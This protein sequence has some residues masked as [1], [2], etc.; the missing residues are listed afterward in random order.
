M[1]AELGRIKKAI[2]IGVNGQDGYFLAK[3]L[4][5]RGYN[6]HGVSRQKKPVSHVIPYINGYLCSDLISLSDASN[7]VHHIL[8]EGPYL[9]FYCA[10][11][12]ASRDNRSLIEPEIVFTVNRDAFLYL[13]SNINLN[14]NKIF[15]FSSRLIYGSDLVGPIFNSTKLNPGCAYGQ[16]KVD[17]I[18]YCRKVYPGHKNIYLIHLFNHE[19]YL[20]QEGFLYNNIMRLMYRNELCALQQ[21]IY[22]LDFYND[23][24]SADYF[25]KYIVDNLDSINNDFNLATGLQLHT[26]EQ[27]M[28]AVKYIFPDSIFGIKKDSMITFDVDVSHLNKN[29]K[30]FTNPIFSQMIIKDFKAF[31]QL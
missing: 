29:G 1:N 16:S 26:G 21:L 12:H 25:M 17:V 31:K 7:L 11:A 6:V 8:L 4:Y 5:K 20:R 18:S 15:Y 9:I 28:Y 30:I 13:L 10:A 27:V 2:V 22:D 3:Y 14:E 24:G 23:W 19:S